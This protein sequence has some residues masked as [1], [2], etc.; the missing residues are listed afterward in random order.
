MTDP[1]VVEPALSAALALIRSAEGCRL[2]SYLDTEGVWT[3]GFGCTGPGIVE[4]VTWTQQHANGELLERTEIAVGDAIAVIGAAY[5]NAIDLAARA[6][7]IDM[8]YELG[9]T[10]LAGFH[11][12]IAAIHIADWP[13]AARQARASV[14]DKQVPQRAERDAHIFE[15]G[16]LPA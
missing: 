14:W 4:G 16:V 2:D 15:T 7:L 9:R 1:V 12:M 13:E 3:V 6:A 10:R 11:D 5:W 8:A